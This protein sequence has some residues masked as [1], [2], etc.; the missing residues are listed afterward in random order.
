M[1][2]QIG[3]PPMICNGLRRKY[4]VCPICDWEVGGYVITGPGDDDWDTH[5]DKFCCQCGQKI[6]WS[7]IN[8]Q[9]INH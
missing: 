3:L 2:Q 9:D 8:F 6:D 1:N 7:H 4:F 5:M